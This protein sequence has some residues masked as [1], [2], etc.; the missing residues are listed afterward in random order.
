MQDLNPQRH[1]PMIIGALLAAAITVIMTL[2]VA[3]LA[4]RR[5]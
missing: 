1:L 4:A 3:S 2:A 5:R